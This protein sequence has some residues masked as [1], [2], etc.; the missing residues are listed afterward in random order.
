MIACAY[1]TSISEMDSNHLH[2]GSGELR[3]L[4][5]T[6]NRRALCLWATEPYY[7]SFR[8]VTALLPSTSIFI[9]RIDD[10]NLSP[11]LDEVMFLLC[12]VVIRLKTNIGVWPQWRRTQDS[13][14]QWLSPSSAFKAD[15]LPIR[16]I[17]HLNG[18][19]KRTSA[20]INNKRGLQLI[21]ICLLPPT[22]QFIGGH[23][24]GSVAR[25]STFFIFRIPLMVRVA[26]LEPARAYAQQIFLL[27]YVTIATLLCCSPEYVFT[28]CATH[29]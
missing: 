5:I 29:T 17:R 15:S 16:I 10:L 6:L 9:L 8:V 12:C 18:R 1:L 24:T 13:N 22:P 28:I 3:Y 23:L 11:L 20:H 25:R 21:R 19:Q 14:L 7:S 27:L 26:G 4:D 2:G